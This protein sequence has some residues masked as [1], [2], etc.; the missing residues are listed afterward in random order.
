[1]LLPYLEPYLIRAMREALPRIESPELREDVQRFCAQE[2]QHDREHARANAAIRKQSPGFARL[3]EIEREIAAE[4]AAFTRERSLRFHLA[5]AE[6]FEALTAAQSRTQFDEGVFERMTGPLRDLMEWQVME[7][8][9]HRTVAF[10]VYQA[11]FGGYWYRL[12]VG[13]WAQW[14]FLSRS[15]RLTR[16]MAQADPEAF[17]ECLDARERYTRS[18]VQVMRGAAGA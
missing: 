17:R 3:A 4:Y 15:F 12:V 11:I 7:E 10:D 14:H 6:G 2:G 1:M 5:Y 13:V 18:A 9:E 16:C 8:L